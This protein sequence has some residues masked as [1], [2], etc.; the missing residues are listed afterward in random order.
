MQARHLHQYSAEILEKLQCTLSLIAVLILEAV[1]FF[2]SSDIWGFL[3]IGEE[4]QRGASVFQDTM[5][6]DPYA[7]PKVFRLA[8]VKSTG[9]RA[10][11]RQE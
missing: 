7:G 6:N 2:V 4:R 9:T 5:S 8:K 11:G 1:L 10:F 3:P